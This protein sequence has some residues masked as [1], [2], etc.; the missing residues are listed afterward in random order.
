MG[1]STW[2]RIELDT[3]ERLT[4]TH[5]QINVLFFLIF[6]SHSKC[7]NKESY[8]CVMSSTFKYIYRKKTVRSGINEAKDV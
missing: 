3:T 6:S 8:A 5:T 7:Y 4:H 1:C 2:G